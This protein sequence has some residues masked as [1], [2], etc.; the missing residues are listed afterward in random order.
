M[1]RFGFQQD[2][3]PLPTCFKPKIW[4][5]PF[6][7]DLFT[8]ESITFCP[9]FASVPADTVAHGQVLVHDYWIIDKSLASGTQGHG[10]GEE[11]RRLIWHQPT[12]VVCLL[13]SP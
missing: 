3:A 2:G 11:L 5:Y 9:I 10:W 4:V 6:F 1:V 7:R 8:K 12:Q 13:D